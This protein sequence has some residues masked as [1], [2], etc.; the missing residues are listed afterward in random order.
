MAIIGN[1][2][3]EPDFFLSVHQC[4]DCELDPPECT[5]EI[6]STCPFY[7]IRNEPEMD[8]DIC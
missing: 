4:I 1:P 3:I 7:R 2:G 6:K 5:D 8:N